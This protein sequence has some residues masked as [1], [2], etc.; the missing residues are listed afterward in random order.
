MP[1][2][3]RCKEHFKEDKA[4]VG[5]VGYG[6]YIPR[7]RIKLETIAAVWGADAE[8]YTRSLMI[9]EKSV[10]SPDQDVISMT[11]EAARHAVARAGIAPAEIGAVYVG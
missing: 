10:P 4:I 9:Y 3:S 6:A 2:Y 8:A 7:N 1:G 5:I 11:V